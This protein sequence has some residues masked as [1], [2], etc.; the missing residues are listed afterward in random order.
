MIA[1]ARVAAYEILRAVSTGRADLPTAIARARG[2]LAD[3]R[4]RALAAEIA[5]GVQRWRAALDHVIE[6]FAKRPIAASRPGDRRGPSSQ[7]L[8]V[9]ASH[10]SAGIRGGGRCGEAR[11]AGGQTQ[12][13]GLRER[14]VANDVAA[15]KRAAFAAAPGRSGRSDASPRLSQRHALPSAWLAARWYDRFGFAAAE[16]WMR[17]DNTAAPLTLRVNR[18]RMTPDELVPPSSRARRRGRPGPIRSG[19]ADRARRAAAVGPGCGCRLVR[20]AGRGFPTRRAARRGAART[21][22]AGHLRGAWRQD[23]GDGGD[24]SGGADR[25][26]RREGSANGPPAADRRRDRRRERRRS[27]RP[28]W[29]GHCPSRTAS[30]A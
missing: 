18:I 12:R 13:R 20:G 23:D 25:G 15:A 30:I 5:T 6:A 21:A 29:P 16:E 3:D 22:C 26:L 4:D 8:S 14:R 11:P 17:F 28:I 19:C 9:A 2:S 27:S 24:R 7:R 1:P 10:A